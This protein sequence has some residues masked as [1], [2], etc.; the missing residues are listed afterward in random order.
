MGTISPLRLIFGQSDSRMNRHENIVCK[1]CSKVDFTGRC[2]RCLSCQDFNM[3]AECYDNDFTTVQHPFDHPVKCVFTPADVELYFGGEYL[4]DPPQSYRCP[5]CKQW[6]YNESTF[7]EHVS[8]EHVGASTLLVSTMVT[9]FEQQQAVR[10]FLEDEQLAVFASAA[11]SRNEL[12]NR[13][14]GSLELFLEPLNPNGSY[15]REHPASPLTFRVAKPGAVEVAPWVAEGGNL[16]ASNSSHNVDNNFL[17]PDPV[18]R[19]SLLDR[20]RHRLNFDRPPQPVQ[21]QQQQPQQQLSGSH[22]PTLSEMMRFNE[23]LPTSRANRPGNFRVVANQSPNQSASG[24][25]INLFGPNATAENMRRAFYPPG[26]ITR[27]RA[28]RHRAPRMQ[29]EGFP[30]SGVRQVHVQRLRGGPGPGPATGPGPG[31]RLVEFSE[32]AHGANELLGQ[33]VASGAVMLRTIEEEE[34][35]QQQPT[36]ESKQLDLERERYL[37]YPFLSSASSAPCPPEEQITFLAQRAEFVAQLLASV[38]C[39]EELTG[40][41][42]MPEAVDT[43]KLRNRSNSEFV[44]A[45]DSELDLKHTTPC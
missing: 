5:Y 7:L 35:Q 17:I 37:C 25:S 18:R 3:C 12:M 14:E 44:G 45:G 21:Q 34:Q 24:R 28:Q 43:L 27:T 10:L 41:T 31:Q 38:L 13:N 39:E 22:H 6:G 20:A 40:I 9:L 11:T 26:E 8:A 29:M 16:T 36:T 23:P 32:L 1:G 15:Q 4:N 33:N 42:S 19:Q 2:Y 30:A